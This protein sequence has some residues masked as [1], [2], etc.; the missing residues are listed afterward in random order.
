VKVARSSFCNAL[1][2]EGILG[3]YN[4]P[5]KPLRQRNEIDVMGVFCAA[6][7]PSPSHDAAVS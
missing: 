7:L 1:I 3:W 2:R 4:P 5:A 6:F